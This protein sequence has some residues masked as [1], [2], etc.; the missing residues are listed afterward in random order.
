MP[1]RQ[2]SS[3]TYQRTRVSAEPAEE[4]VTLDEA[5]AHARI[6]DA[7]EDT[8]ITSY[9]KA[10]RLAVEKYTTRK[11]V[12]QSLETFMDEFPDVGDGA[13]WGGQRQGTPVSTGITSDRSID[14]DWLPVQD[15]TQISTF[16][17]A[18][19]ESTF[20]A[21]EFR[22]D[23]NDPDLKARIS[24]TEGAVW[25][26]DLRPTNAVRILYD[27]GYGLPSA[28]PP[29]VPE[30]IKLAIKELVAYWIRQ[31]EAV[32]APNLAEVPLAY[33]YLIDQYRQERI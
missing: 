31:R 24:L 26:T 1:H 10:A 9:I 12:T 2:R 15:V 19:V 14:L 11:L 33:R 18:D 23:K 7:D 8:L 27:V 29:D 13:W 21:T 4:P 3:R 20:P 17:D 25:P 28:A 32:C 30:D 16:N 5:K 22:V 6:L